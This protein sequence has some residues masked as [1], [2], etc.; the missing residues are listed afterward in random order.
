MRKKDCSS[1][2]ADVRDAGKRGDDSAAARY[3]GNVAAVCS[4]PGGGTL[5]VDAWWRDCGGSAD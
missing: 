3:H 1:L 4:L 5:S 2:T